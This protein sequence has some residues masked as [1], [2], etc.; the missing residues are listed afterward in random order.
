MADLTTLTKVKTYLGISGSTQ[1]TLLSS[2]ITAVSAGIESFCG[3]E[4]GSATHTEYYDTDGETKIFLPNY[5]VSSLTSV[6]YQTGTWDNITWTTYPASGYLLTGDQGRLSFAGTLPK[7]TK[8]LQIVY[9][10]GYL[11]DFD[12]EGTAT[13]TLP[14][15]LTQIVNELIASTYNTRSS[16]GINTMSTEGQSITFSTQSITK[17]YQ[18]R[19]ARYINYK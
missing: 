7:I 2:L 8:Y 10:G 16:G 14:Y 4:F 17:D 13:H 19:L 11:I 9:V 1:D 6:K 12:N 15:D 5:P 18:N 3:R